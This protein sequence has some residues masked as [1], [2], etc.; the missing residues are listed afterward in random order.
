MSWTLFEIAKR[1]TVQA[2]MR[3]EILEM[4]DRLDARGDLS[5]SALDL[6]SLQYTDAVL[7]VRPNLFHVFRPLTLGNLGMFQTTGDNRND[8]ERSSQGRRP[9]AF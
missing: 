4:K 1:P 3:T 2:R 7:R 9:P 5:P 8:S 6:E